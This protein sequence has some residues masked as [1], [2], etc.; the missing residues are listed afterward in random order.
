MPSPTLVLVGTGSFARSVARS[1]LPPAG[2][3][4]RV[5]VVGRRAA[6][7]AQLAEVCNVRAAIDRSP[8]TFTA[9]E[10]DLTSD[11]AIAAEVAAARPRIVVQCASWQSPWERATAPSAW[12]ELCGRA[13]FGITLA[14]QA[15]LVRSVSARLAASGCSGVLLNA[16]YPDAVNP[17]L[18]LLGSE[19]LAGLGNVST[20]AA[21]LARAVTRAEPG[22]GAAHVRML[23]HHAHLHAPAAP[24]DEAMAWLGETRLAGVGEL[25]RP[26]RAIDRAELNDIAGHA[27]ARLIRALLHGEPLRT[28]C[29]GP[30]GLPGGYPVTVGGGRLRLDLPPGLTRSRAVEWNQRMAALDGV[31]VRPDGR[32]VHPPATARALRPHLPHVAAGFDADDAADVADDLLAL[33]RRL[34]TTTEERTKPC[35]ARC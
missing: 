20:L 35:A 25:L 10:E 14:L 1:L 28:N 26:L 31:I 9:N 18:S 34:R 19:V 6:R 27:A 22:A 21:G 15:R 4:A 2:E 13:G 32:V 8:V 17:L 23:A 30:L 12:T 16:C 33:R 29:P 3:H 7:A 24:R 5:R 11:D